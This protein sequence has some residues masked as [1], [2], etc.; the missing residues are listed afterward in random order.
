MAAACLWGRGASADDSSDATRG[1]I[2][3]DL[4]FV[5]G[6]GAVVAPR[7][8]R[9]EGE[10]RV[11]YLDSAG[12]F[13][14]Y[15]DALGLGSDPRRV[16]G[17]GLEIR[18]LFLGRWLSGLE[19]PRARLDLAADSFGLELGLFVSEPTGAA[20]WK[21]GLQAGVGLEI[22]VLP[23][24]S[25]PWLGLHGGVRWSDTAIATG[26]VT[27]VEDRAAYLAI[28]VAWHQTVETHLVDLGDRPPQ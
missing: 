7:A 28:T 18:P 11:R 3:G 17:A 20:G 5:F 19:T 2:D 4:T 10:I 24:A 14:T 12:G 8:P 23:K 6:A 16:L 1:R 27:N 9:F 26:M 13:V 15:E 22:P 25:G 21:G